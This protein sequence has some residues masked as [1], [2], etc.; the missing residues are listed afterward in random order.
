VLHLSV[1]VDTTELVEDNSVQLIDLRSEG[2]IDSARSGGAKSA[3]ET[4]CD[5]QTLED[6]LGVVVLDSLDEELGDLA[7]LPCKVT[8]AGL[9]KRLGSEEAAEDA[10]GADCSIKVRLVV[11]GVFN[12][13]P[14]LIEGLIELEL[15]KQGVGGESFNR[16][17][18]NL[19]FLALKRL[20]KSLNHKLLLLLE[21]LSHAELALHGSSA[22]KVMLNCRFL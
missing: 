9:L 2:S 19:I 21:T 1:D 15:G 14:N 6:N 5:A 16:G 13:L 8:G 7:S 20:H 3:E 18:L 12:V 4:A 10:K 11:D 22:H 17:N